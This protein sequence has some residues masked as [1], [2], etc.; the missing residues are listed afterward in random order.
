M[1]LDHIAIAVRDLESAADRLCGLLGYHRAT[2]RVTNTRQQVH[3]M[4]LRKQGSLDL[5]LIEPSS[6][7]SPLWPFVRK[8]GG[9]HHVCFKTADVNAACDE[10]TAAGARMLAA[11][12]PGEAFEDGLIA[13]LYAGLGLNVEVID[14]DARRGTLEGENA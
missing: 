3:V 9:L 7:Q 5:K 10:L 2:A 1:N 11:P 8:G 13:F 14:T 12:A 4:F 6:D